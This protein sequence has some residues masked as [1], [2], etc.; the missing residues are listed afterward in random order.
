MATRVRAP[1][2]PFA[3]EIVA[4][5]NRQAM[6]RVYWS[7]L[8]MT[9]FDP[10]RSH[11]HGVIAGKTPWRRYRFFFETQQDLR[12]I[13]LDLDKKNGQMQVESIRL[14]RAEA[15]VQA[16]SLEHPLAN[17][18]Q[19]GFDVGQAIDGNLSSD[20]GW[21][22][23]PGAGLDQV[24]VFETNEVLGAS[25]DSL[26]QVTLHQNFGNGEHSLGKF[27][28]SV[29]NSP[30]PLSFGLPE[31]I[32]QLLAI[33]EEE[34][35]SKQQRN[36]EEY[37]RANDEELRKLQQAIGAAQAP[38]PED[39]IVTQFE[40]T[41]QRLRKTLPVDRLAGGRRLSALRHG[42]KTSSTD[43]RFISRV[44][45]FARHYVQQRQRPTR[46]TGWVHGRGA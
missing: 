21:S 28:I 8:G 11:L 22:S 23:E 32:V 17:S 24:A 40:Q 37:F 29:S 46:S 26:I 34:R 12:G 13:R 25:D 16:I 39:P 6:M 2:G 38:L 7:T 41:I 4:K 27:R 36:L 3:L 33:A 45:A 35:T 1:A 5:V 44:R 15:G 31:L 19:A 42:A 18:N 43:G 9:D 10:A 14:L 30:K 20:N